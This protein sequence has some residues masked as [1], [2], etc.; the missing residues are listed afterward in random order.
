MIWRGMIIEEE[1]EHRTEQ[2]SGIVGRWWPRKRQQ[3]AA[4]QELQ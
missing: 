3:T 2:E 4:E 1:H